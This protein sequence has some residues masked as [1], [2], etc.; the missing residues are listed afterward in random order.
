MGARRTDGR[1]SLAAR[2]TEGRAHCRRLPPDLYKCGGWAVGCG[3]AWRTMN[4]R[5]VEGLA[6][7]GR[8]LK[9]RGHCQRH[10]GVDV[11]GGIMSLR[12]SLKRGARWPWRASDQ[13]GT[14]GLRRW[15]QDGRRAADC[16]RQGG[17]RARMGAR[18]TG[19]RG[20]EQ[21]GRRGARCPSAPPR[22]RRSIA[23]ALPLHGG[24]D[25]PTRGVRS[26]YT[27]GFTSLHGKTGFR[28]RKAHG[29]R[30]FRELMLGWW[31]ARM[32]ARHF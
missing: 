21:D 25:L 1:G 7:R 31:D 27:E 12:W 10:Q 5:M 24:C 14:I 6:A 19:G 11:A 4:W 22:R 20:W 16:W 28:T 15:E 17:R 18:R 32:A 13:K 2:R 3:D 23:L 29:G 26:P 30:R 9:Q 8:E